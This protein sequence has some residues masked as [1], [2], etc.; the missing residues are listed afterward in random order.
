MKKFLT[1][2]VCAAAAISGGA[3][4]WYIDYDRLPPVSQEIIQ[5]NFSHET[6]KSVV[7]AYE[8]SWDR[9]IVC[10]C[11]G[12]RVFFD[13]DSGDC[14]EIVMKNGSIPASVLPWTLCSYVF[15]Q[16]P[17][18]QM[19]SYR[20]F[21]EGYRLGLSDDTVLDFDKDGNFVRAAK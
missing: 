17:Y 15:L 18:A 6:V 5:K 12:N 10:F 1:L 2:F 7:V 14:F 11:S 4:S 9:Y 20:V 3:T 19:R 13:G 8:A 16:Y 21:E